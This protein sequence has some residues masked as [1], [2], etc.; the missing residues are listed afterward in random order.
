[1]VSSTRRIALGATRRAHGVDLGLDFL[2][3]HWGKFGCL[4][5]LADLEELASRFALECVAERT[6]N[7]FRTEKA[8]FARLAREVVRQCYS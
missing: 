5:R 8:C 2:F 6:L 1:M 4:H 3:A 7:S